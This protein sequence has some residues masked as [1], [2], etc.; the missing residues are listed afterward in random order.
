MI[1]KMSP[2]GQFVAE[3]IH[4]IDN[5]LSIVAGHT[6]HLLKKFEKLEFEKI[7]R[8]DLRDLIETLK[9]ICE[10]SMRCS[11]ITSDVLMSGC[12]ETKPQKVLTDINQRL[13]GILSVLNR[14]LKFSQINVEKQISELPLVLIDPIQLD[15]V[16][17]NIILNA[18]QAMPK[19]G[20]LTI[21][22]SK[23]SKQR[24]KIEIADTGVG[25]PK[26]NLN[27]VVGPLFT[28]RNREGRGGLGLTIVNSIIK[29]HHGT[30]KID[31]QIGQGTVVTIYL[32]IPVKKK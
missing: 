10:H 18:R 3:A 27:K 23:V 14:Q 24:I 15:R 29:H 26:E 32:P 30:I 1:K 28:T 25:I 5:L 2:L 11:Q 13:E 9:M 21:S 12:K 16:F 6:Q 22:T 17:M 8:E 19:G 20:K 7:R 4:E 31:S